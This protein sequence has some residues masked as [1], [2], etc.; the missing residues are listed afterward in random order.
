[1]ANTITQT[2]THCGETKPLDRE[3]Y[4]RNKSYKTGFLRRCK[5]CQMEHVTLYNQSNPQYWERYRIDN[6]Q[7]IRDYYQEYYDTDQP[8]KIYAI[9]NPNGECYIGMSQMRDWMIR[10][11]QHK[12]SHRVKHGSYPKLHESIDKW[13]WDTHRFI[14]IEE[15]QTKDR[16]RGMCRESMWIQHYE[17]MGKSLNVNGTK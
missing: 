13:G 5:P 1:M 8:I 15:M 12:S 4:H 7:Y 16:G 17:K 3:H 10:I 9:Q 11:S 2:C 14:L 6:E